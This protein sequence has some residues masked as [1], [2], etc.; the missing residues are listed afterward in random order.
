MN[1]YFDIITDLFFPII[2][3]GHSVR[4]KKI[5]SMLLHTKAMIETY[6]PAVIVTAYQSIMMIPKMMLT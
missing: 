2:W 3:T 1:I 5:V 4:K 6:F